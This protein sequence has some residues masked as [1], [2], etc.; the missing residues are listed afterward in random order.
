MRKP[1]SIEASTPQGSRQTWEPR[2][3]VFLVIRRLSNRSGG[4]ERLFCEMANMFADAGYDVT[5]LTCEASKE[6][7]FYFLDP[8]VTRLN[9]WGRAARRAP[10]YGFLDVLAKTYDG[11]A[12]LAPVDWASKNLY[13]LRRLEAVFRTAKPDV[14]ISFM[15]PANTV[16]LLAGKTAGVPV[17]PTNHNVPEQDFTSTERWDQNPIDRSLRLWSLYAAARVHVLTPSFAAWFPRRLRSKVVA[18]TNYVPPEFEDVPL[19]AP[20]SK[21]ILAVGR[22][23]PVK[24]YGLLIE[25]WALIAARHPD[26]RVS[27]YGVGPLHAE[28]ERQ[29]RTL[30]LKHKVRLMGECNAMRPV[31]SSAEIF[32]HPALFEGFGLSAAEALAC[33]LPVVVFSDCA[34]INEFVHNEVNGLTISRDAGARGLADALERLIVDRELRLRLRVAAPASISQLSF[35][36]FRHRWIELV[37]EVR[38]EAQDRLPEHVGEVERAL[39]L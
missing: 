6:P 21:E 8:K 39:A 34:G 28:L 27:I 9:L 29:I 13:F 20:R 1:A 32:C 19:S 18:L 35:A 38:R 15:P 30:D 25:A 23:A 7:P 31:Y 2:G 37:E 11:T 26:W 33:G 22:L 17:I 16:S 14:V 24:N 3:R 10:W 12:L 5:C 4:A 36:N